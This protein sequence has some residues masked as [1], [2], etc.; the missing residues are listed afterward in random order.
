MPGFWL[1]FL[2]GTAASVLV[3]PGVRRVLAPI[4]ESIWGPDVTVAG[5]GETQLLSACQARIEDDKIMPAREMPVVEFA[6]PP[7]PK[8]FMLPVSAV[9]PPPIAEPFQLPTVVQTTNAV[10]GP[11][12]QAAFS[13]SGAPT[14][15]IVG[16]IE[17]GVLDD[18]FFGR[19]K[20]RFANDPE[21]RRRVL[22]FGGAGAAGL[23]LL[24]RRKK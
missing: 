2:A 16:T 12:E 14:V 10:I 20:A 5:I 22:L 21:Y 6:P 24:R 19:F 3:G 17:N 8:V 7:I 18:S 9:P 23:V 11:A 4:A 13:T 1:P 15:E